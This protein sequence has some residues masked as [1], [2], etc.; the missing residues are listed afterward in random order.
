MPKACA[1]IG[2]QYLAYIFATR[3]RAGGS[4]PVFVVVACEGPSPCAAPPSKPLGAERS[5]F[6]AQLEV[7]RV[8]PEHCHGKQ[9]EV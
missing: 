2:A 4:S 7:V 6:R 1:H 3:S 9:A 5:V 8:A